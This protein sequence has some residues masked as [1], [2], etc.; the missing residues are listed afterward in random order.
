TVLPTRGCEWSGNA[1]AE[2]SPALSTIAS[3]ISNVGGP[4]MAPHAPRLGEAVALREC[5]V[6]NETASLAGLGRAQRAAER[7]PREDLR[8]D[9]VQVEVDLSEHAHVLAGRR[10]DRHH[11]LEPDL[12]ILAEPQDAG[13]DR[14]GG[15]GGL[16]VV[17]RRLQRQLDDG[18][19]AA[20]RL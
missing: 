17:G 3:R 6:V 16:G 15:P 7:R 11:R 1:W 12:H 14:P 5:P 2:A 13:I 4:D 10:V 9:V 19:H 18:D 20:E 8:Q